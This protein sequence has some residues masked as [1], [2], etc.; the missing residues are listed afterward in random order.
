MHQIRWEKNINYNKEKQHASGTFFFCKKWPGVFCTANFDFWTKF[1]WKKKSRFAKTLCVLWN[2]FSIDN[3]LDIVIAFMTL[4]V[5][6]NMKPFTGGN[7]QLRFKNDIFFKFDE[8]V[9]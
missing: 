6:L 1:G 2:T 8:R 5:K 3:Q 7:I 4:N 9:M